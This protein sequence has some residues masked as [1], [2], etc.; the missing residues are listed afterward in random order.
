MSWL[1]KGPVMSTTNDE[2]APDFSLAPDQCK[3]HL[4]QL[5]T[6]SYTNLNPCVH[7]LVPD[8][9]KLHCLHAAGH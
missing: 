2:Q 6:D 9:E 7:K 8:D 1:E 3:T 4:G 5:H